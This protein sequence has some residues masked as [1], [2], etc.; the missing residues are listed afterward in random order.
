MKKALP[1]A[2]ALHAVIL[3]IGLIALSHSQHRTI[4][5]RI[6]SA[7]VDGQPHKAASMPK[8]STPLAASKNPDEA[9]SKTD[10]ATGNEVNSNLTGIQ[11]SSY[12]KELVSTNPSPDY[13]PVA[14]LHHVEGRVVLKITMA[15][16]ASGDALVFGDLKLEESSGSEAL[17]GSVI[18]TVKKWRF[19][20]LPLQGKNT[21]TLAFLL[22]FEFSLQ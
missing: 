5:V 22:P 10:Q 20:P 7:V 18:Q 4:T 11:V 13:P 16:S 1:L 6:L 17:D 15:P 8:R 19:P 3:V 2:I 12:F 21:Q 14:R 9:I